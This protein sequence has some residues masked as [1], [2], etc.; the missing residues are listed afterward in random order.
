MFHD[1]YFP[2]ML[3]VLLNCRTTLVLVRIWAT[4]RPVS[5]H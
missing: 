4:W 1:K 5:I 3:Q 2:V